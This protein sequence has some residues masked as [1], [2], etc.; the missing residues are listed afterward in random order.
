[1][2]ISAF[3][4]LPQTVQPGSEVTLSW[5]L[6]GADTALIELY[7]RANNALAGTFQELPT[8]GSANLIIPEAFTDGARFVLWAADRADDGTF[9][10]LVRSEVE[11]M[12]N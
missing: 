9:I 2:R 10:R 3:I 5:S 8:I 6:T 7:N 1:M 11:V 12:A 4:A